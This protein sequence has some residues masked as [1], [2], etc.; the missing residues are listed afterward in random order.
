PALWSHTLSAAPRGLSLAR[1]KGWL[2]TW[3]EQH[4]LYLFDRAGKLQGQRQFAGG[5]VGAC[6]ADDGSALAALGQRGEVWWLLPDLSSRWEQ[7]L[8]A[9]PVTAAIDSFGQYLAVADA[10]GGLHLLDR[11]GRVFGTVQS[12]RPFHHL[13]FVPTKCYLACCSDFGLVAAVDFKGRWAWRDGLVVH[14]G[15]LAVS[16]DGEQIVLACFTEGLHRYSMTGRKLEPIRTSEPARL[17][18]LTFDDSRML[19]SGLSRQMQ[20]L[21]GV[22]SPLRRYPLDQPPTALAIAPLGQAAFVALPTGRLV[23]LDLAAAEPR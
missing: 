2:L 11:L 9:R 19:V 13:S 16:G 4:W 23:A 15:G 8:P 7:Q 18:S 14:V 10:Q 5:L 12:P 3:D 21:D 17:V 20:L 22:G 6:C 1:E